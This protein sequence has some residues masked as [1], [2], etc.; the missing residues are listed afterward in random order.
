MCGCKF[1]C[2]K[3]N[4]LHNMDNVNIAISKELN[5]EDHIVTEDEMKR[6]NVALNM[7]TDQERKIIKKFYWYKK[8]FRALARENNL[9]YRKLIGDKNKVI[10][11]IKG[12]MEE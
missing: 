2:K 1:T 8:S 4:E 10:E 11:K 7:I 3:N 6:L 5:I 12:M 9:N